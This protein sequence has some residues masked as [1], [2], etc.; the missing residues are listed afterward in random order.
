MRCN[1]VT[2]KSNTVTI[3]IVSTALLILIITAV[4]YD[5]K[6]SK[7]VNQESYL[8]PDYDENFDVYY[9]LDNSSNIYCKYFDSTEF[10]PIGECI[11]G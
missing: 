2:K 9:D 6:D 11:D 8:N 3:I 7:K 10:K 4:V 1:T 5:N